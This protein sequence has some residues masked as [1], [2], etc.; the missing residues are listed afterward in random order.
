MSE[1]ELKAMPD[2]EQ[3]V[4]AEPSHDAEDRLTPEFVS[5][6]L[7]RVDAGDS[8][9]ARALVDPLHHADIADLFEL[10]PSDQ[11]RA[12]AAAMRSILEEPNLLRRF[13]QNARKPDDI[14]TTA[15]R[16]LKRIEATQVQA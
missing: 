13:S 2:D 8:E 15:R 14:D 16:Y 10:V 5:A 3:P 4:V 7:D 6:V 11:R 1:S 12:L 9:G